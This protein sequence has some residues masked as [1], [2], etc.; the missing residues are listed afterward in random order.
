MPSDQRLGKH[1]SSMIA[2]MVLSK[3]PAGMGVGLVRSYLETRWGFQTGRQDGAL[4][5]AT[6]MQPPSRIVSDE[7]ANLFLDDVVKKYAHNSGLALPSSGPMAGSSEVQ[8]NAVVL[9]AKAMAALTDDQRI[10]SRVLMEAYARFL[11][12]DQ[13]E[14][15]RALVS[16]RK[17][18]EE[19][20]AELFQLNA[21]LG[22]SFTSGIQPSFSIQ[23]A[24]IYDSFWNWTLQDLMILVFGIESGRL[25]ITDQTVSQL[26]LSIV[27]R[28][29]PT[30]IKSIQYII[31]IT[32][33]GGFKTEQSLR[34][35]LLSLL[36]QCQHSL[37]Q[38]PV[39]KS[40]SI[41]TAPRTTIDEQGK[42][43][44]SEVPRP[45]E[46]KKQ[47]TLENGY[48]DGVIKLEP[49]T[50]AFPPFKFKFKKRG[51]HGWIK[52]AVLERKY[53][54]VL[55]QTRDT[56]I[57]FR[58]KCVLLTG[59]GR[60][61]IGTEI[62]QGLISGGAK[63]VVATSSFSSSVARYFQMIYAR[64]GA[65]G[66]QL[67]VVP[68]NQGSQQDVASLVSYIYDSVNGLGWDLDLIIPF[69]AIR[70]TGKQMDEIDSISELAQRTMLVN[71]LRLLGAIKQQK[72]RTGS[73]NRPVQIILPLSPNH[74]IFGNDGLYAESK[75][76]LETLFNKWH[77][78]DWSDY[79]S[80]CGA[81]I[82][83]TRGTGLMS[84]N[85]IL[86]EG[87]EKLGIRIF[88]RQEMATYILSLIST[89]V[90][91]FCHLEPILADISGGLEAFPD[92]NSDL[93]SIRENLTQT[94]EIQRAIA[95]EARIEQEVIW[96]NINNH[97]YLQ[98]L[99]AIDPRPNIKFPFPRLPDFQTDLEPLKKFRG[100]VDLDRVVVVAGYAEVGPHGSSRTRWE[101][102][103]YGEFSLEGC[104]ELAWI[105]GL[106]QYQNTTIKGEPYSGWVDTKTREPVD[107]RDVKRKYENHILEH[108]GVRIIEPELVDGY[109]PN[110]KQLLQEIVLQTDLDP[111]E[112]SVETAQ[113]F[114][115]EHGDK[116][117]I[118]Q[119]ATTSGEIMVRFKK[120]AILMVPKALKFDRQ[121]AGQIPTGWN[122]STYGISDEI[123]SQVDP[124]TLYA[125]VCTAESLLSSGIT[126]PYEFYQY[127]HVS[128]IGQCI[129]SSM[130]GLS[131][132]KK[133]YKDRYLD[134]PVQADILQETFINT[135]GAWIN[136]LL[137]SASGPMKT[138]VGACATSI[139]SLDTGYD[140]ITSG[141][142]KVCFVGG[143]EKFTEDI[144]FEFVNMKATS[145]SAD[146]FAK[147]R[148]A[149]DIS[150][151]TAS[152]RS[153]LALEM[154]LPIHGIVALTTTASDKVG[155][156]V[157]APEY[158][159]E[160]VAIRK[161]EDPS[162]DQ[163]E[164]LLDRR[165]H[166]ELE[167]QRQEKEV[168]YSYGNNFWK[169]DPLISPIRGALATWGLTIDDIG[170]ASMHGTSTVMNEKNES[171][172]LQRQLSHLGRAKGNLMF[173]VCQ[174]SLTGHPKGAAGA[175]MFNGGLQMLDTGLVPGNR[176]ADN[177]DQALEAFDYLCFPNHSIKTHGIKAFFVT[178]FGF[179]QK[180][181]QAIGVHAK[182][183]FA[184]LDETAYRTY[185]A[186]VE[187]RQKKAYQYFH[188]ALS[189][190]SMFLAKT[191]S[192]NCNPADIYSHNQNVRKP[193]SY[194]RISLIKGVDSTLS[195]TDKTIHGRKR[196][197]LAQGLSDAHMRVLEP[198]ILE[199][200][201]SLSSRLGEIQDDFSPQALIDKDGWTC[202]K[203]MSDW[204]DFFT[205]DVMSELVFGTS[206]HML[207][208]RDSHF[209]VHA[210]AGQTK[211]ISFL[212]QFPI[213]ED[214]GLGRILYP[215]AAKKAMQFSRASRAIMEARKAKGNVDR[216]DLYST[217]LAAKDP[218][219]N[220]GFSLGEL[221]DTTSTALAA[222][223]FYLSRNAEA[224]TKVVEEVRSTFASPRDIRLGPTLNSCVYLRACLEESMRLSP[225]AGAAMWREVLEGGIVVDGQYI[226]AGYELGVGIYS[227][228]HHPDPFPS[229]FS[230][231]PER[232][233]VSEKNS[234]E[235]VEKA[236]SAF[237]TFSIG[238]RSCIGR[239]LA[240][241]EM[242]LFMARLI[243]EYE[244]RAA[245]APLGKV[246][247]GVG[248]RKSEYQTLYS[249]TSVK[250]GPYIQFR[251]REI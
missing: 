201:R 39:F 215:G 218:E 198:A 242:M 166:I 243:H 181:A 250:D 103:A 6:T 45:V 200:V 10:L 98:Q 129:G 89:P 114:Q 211:R 160:Q 32:L 118:V 239:G 220:N 204:G 132:L 20:K 47:Y 156:S 190:N 172:V 90:A 12:V 100:M 199:C 221:A 134:K 106:I 16:S 57:S 61:S 210:I 64:Y 161:A 225:P 13:Q 197:I 107:D 58:G 48:T 108:T 231:R 44:Y 27:N 62:L 229:P 117:E 66:T 2:R 183:L 24:R 125:L 171:A 222:T 113:Q 219:T 170:V 185:R 187:A 97:R 22:E 175:W 131:S 85:D 40:I 179:G 74:G 206:F 151:P 142:A 87:I 169:N 232:W 75:L 237:S 31:D 21:E 213:I 193:D 86:S 18:I 128:D 122:A 67:V 143:F 217:I 101:M 228:H 150:R 176:N 202:A 42:L 123:I 226:P 184:T 71:V 81:V 69:A 68:F 195:A 96:G 209:I 251:K 236:K 245:N 186:K 8:G 17:T 216:K 115:R 191:D 194:H 14:G 93:A 105:M 163:S 4:V 51:R 102:E 137:L 88:S 3:M 95:R 135:T 7:A 35:L 139:E 224:Y 196:R 192:P 56:G 154:G 157:P 92:L 227:L 19:L 111:F 80:I 164:Y 162:S 38:P 70:E 153:G 36:Q 33:R 65:R 146:D 84:S 214:L 244:F 29:T 37:N 28:S 241:V 94:S 54:D 82:G 208:R 41:L 155:R 11:K 83:W 149:K 49:V 130:G 233:L 15:E 5:F 203:N 124:V 148:E 77:T 104:I 178:S 23:K 177:V 249:F 234:K 165:Q 180:G 43:K 1:T 188:R 52:D 248:D 120:G 73:L 136:M 30:L 205:F 26:S 235:A 168:L 141:K 109:D 127:I 147:G 34:I 145:S 25:D 247:E 121:V 167:V 182:Y 116:V 53:M 140:L 50:I 59:A 207:Q 112:V 60:G 78:E 46:I 91:R 174:K 189:T 212:T 138:P 223:F 55:R 173:G 133:L 159:E 240:I 126:D 119:G 144:S 238:P 9:D 110:K 152:T 246:G 76:A 79:I 230:F 63:V 99:G 72:Q 158:L